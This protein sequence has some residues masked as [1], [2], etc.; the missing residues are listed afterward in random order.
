M[1]ALQA[2]LIE[3]GIS[4]VWKTH[5]DRVRC[6]DR[7]IISISAA[8]KELEADEFVVAAGVWSDDMLRQI[9]LKIP[10]QAGKGY[11][12]TL[13]TPLLSINS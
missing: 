7:K 1:E 10:M 6:E 2:N 3:R 8:G 11:S 12:L 5:V 13:P 9:G 4:F